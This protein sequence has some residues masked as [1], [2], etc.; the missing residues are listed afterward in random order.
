MLTP[1]GSGTYTYQ[2]FGYKLIEIL[3][4]LQVWDS[5][6][7]VPINLLIHHKPDLTSP[8]CMEQNVQHYLQ[9]A[10][11]ANTKCSYAS[12]TRRFSD[13]CSSSGMQPYPASE[14][15]LCQFAAHLGKQNL[16]HQ[17]IKCYLAGIRF[18]QI[19]QTSHDPFIK[20]N[21]AVHPKIEEAIVGQQPPVTPSILLQIHNVEVG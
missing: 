21:Y 13:F 20:D 11:S 14:S 6:M 12:S 8:H 15:T 5:L 10:V 4:H 19:M 2:K 16:K 9:S 17:T 18:S 7:L 1:M 3:T